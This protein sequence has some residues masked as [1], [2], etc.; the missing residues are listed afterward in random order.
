MAVNI[1]VILIIPT[2]TNTLLM[3]NEN[4]TDN[5]RLS[6][7]SDLE[8]PSMY[9]RAKLIVGET[10]EVSILRRKVER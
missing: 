4:I 9:K 8:L 2:A 3:V 10:D 1:E 5:L 6:Q 7:S